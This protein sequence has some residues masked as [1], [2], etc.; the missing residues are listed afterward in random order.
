ML[1]LLCVCWIC[2]TQYDKAEFG[3]QPPPPFFTICDLYPPPHTVPPPE[4]REKCRDA[5]DELVAKMATR[6]SGRPG[7][8][9]RQLNSEHSNG[10]LNIRVLKLNDLTTHIRRVCKKTVRVFLLMG[11]FNPNEYI[12]LEKPVALAVRFRFGWSCHYN[13][14]KLEKSW[15]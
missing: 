3:G 5:R 7:S 8:M 11:F 2:K 1:L 13:R 14:R 6:C 12:A 9:S 10:H 15:N 4:R